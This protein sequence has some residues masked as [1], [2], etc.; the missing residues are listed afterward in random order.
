VPGI[1]GLWHNY[2]FHEDGDADTVV[3]KTGIALLAAGVVALPVVHVARD[4][5]LPQSFTPLGINFLVT[6]LFAVGSFA[7][8]WKINKIDQY[9]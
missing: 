1:E 6:L 9:R 3:D 4:Y 7:V 5:V 8:T 2:T